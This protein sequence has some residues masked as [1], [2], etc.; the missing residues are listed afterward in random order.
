MSRVDRIHVLGAHQL[1]LSYYQ[2]LEQAKTR[3]AL[4]YKKISCISEN[5][6]E[7]ILSLIAADENETKNDLIVPDHTAKHVLLEVFMEIAKRTS[8]TAQVLLA[9]FEADFSPP[10]LKKGDNNSI[11]A[12]SYATWIC[13]PDCNEPAVCPHIQN[14]RTWDFHVSLPE[15]FKKFPKPL[16]SIHLFGC[17]PLWGEISQISVSVIR[18]EIEKLREQLKKEKPLRVIVAT[19]SH[20]H[21]ILGQFGLSLSPNPNM[22]CSVIKKTDDFIFL[23]KSAQVH[24][25]AHRVT[26]TESVANWLLTID[27][28]LP[29]VANPLESG[30]VHRLDL[31]TSGIMVA[32]RN[33]ESFDHLKKLWKEGKVEKEYVCMVDEKPPAS[34]TYSAFASAQSKKKVKIQTKQSSSL[35]TKKI[36]TEIVSSK[37]CSRG[38]LVTVRL[39]TG[40]RHQ[41]RAHLAFLGCPIR[42]DRLYGGKPHNRLM[43]QASRL[44]FRAADSS[45]I[46]VSLPPHTSFSR[47]TGP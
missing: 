9:P 12:M 34:G 44:S 17:S 19:H 29:H 38:F 41:I 33:R 21:A 37:P 39:I 15:L 16:T 27:P 11:W 24:S 26:E 46:T 8:P 1:A 47:Q 6:A 7:F 22:A 18:Q 43:L 42:G 25:V 2:K 35:K 45:R 3:G 36:M 23:Y 31:E 32:A 28:R 20:C 10:F 40:Y 4:D 14:D 30:L 5:Y 13:P